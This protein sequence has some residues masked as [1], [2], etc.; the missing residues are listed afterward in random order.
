MK[1]CAGI[2]FLRFQFGD[3]ANPFLIGAGVATVAYQD[4]LITKLGPRKIEQKREKKCMCC[5]KSH[6][7]TVR[8]IY[9]G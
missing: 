4:V 6:K 8:L 1:S 9:I 5:I 7:L 2:L 3:L